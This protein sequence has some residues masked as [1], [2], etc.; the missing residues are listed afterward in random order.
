MAQPAAIGMRLGSRNQVS[1]WV[2]SVGT[3]GG[4]GL[5]GLEINLEMGEK[6]LLRP[7]ADLLRQLVQQLFSCYKPP[8]IISL[9]ASQSQ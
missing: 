8:V 5:G 6:T 9:K 4:V 7:A 1:S 2:R 3:G